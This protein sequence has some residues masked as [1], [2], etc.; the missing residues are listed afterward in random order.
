[1]SN[2]HDIELTI[3]NMH[4]TGCAS[5]IE[6][7][8]R[9]LGF[10]DATVNFASSSAHFSLEHQDSLAQVITEIERLGYEVVKPGDVARSQSFL[11]TLRGRFIFSLAWTVPLFLHM[12]ISWHWLHEPMVQLALCL[13]VLR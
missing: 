9:G 10:K 7:H 1:M 6:K 8:L 2:N 4:C 3:N 12:F 5:G 13:P 11:N